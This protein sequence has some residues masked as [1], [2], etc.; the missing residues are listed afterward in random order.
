MPTYEYECPGGDNF[1]DITA[2]IH[3]VVSTPTCSYCGATMIR[4]YSNPGVIF[5]AQGFYKTDNRG[6]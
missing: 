2:S 1:V 6:G 4:V 3:D 5:N